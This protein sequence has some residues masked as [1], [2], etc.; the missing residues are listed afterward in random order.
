M[1]D[2]LTGVPVS[3]VAGWMFGVVALVGG[4]EPTCDAVCT[5][6]LACGLEDAPRVSQTE[7]E[8]TCNSRASQ[9]EAWQDEEKQDAYVAHKRC[10]V[11][12]TCDEIADGFCYDPLLF[13]F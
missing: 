3:R 9:Y 13:Q 8:D 11:D 10:L 7:C 6:T 1:P 4:C 5:Q 2:R 12:A